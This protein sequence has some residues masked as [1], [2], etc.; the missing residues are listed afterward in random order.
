MFDRTLESLERE[1]GFVVPDPQR[2][3]LKRQMPTPTREQLLGS[4]TNG[5]TYFYRHPDQFQAFE[6]FL[7]T[8]DPST[9]Q[10][11][12]SAG[13]STGCEPYSIAMALDKAHRSGRVLGTDISA[14]RLQEARQGV[15]RES[16]VLRLGFEDK[17]RYFS[18]VGNELWKVK[19]FLTNSVSFELE[20]LTEKTGPGMSRIWDVIFCRN[21][22]IYFDEAMAREILGR[23]VTRLQAGGLLVLGYPEAFFGLSHPE[24]VLLAARTAIFTRVTAQRL[25]PSLML[26]STPPV[27]PVAIRPGAFQEGLRR[28]AMGDLDE[29]RRCFAEAQEKESGL[30]LVH[31]FSARLFDELKQP[32]QAA[33][34]L[35]KFFATYRED[36]PEVLAFTQR[37]GVSLEQLTLAATRLRDRLERSLA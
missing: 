14:E 30:S 19:P 6:G 22:L 32:M 35:Q 13:C 18:S 24:L 8:C 5:Q 21:V 37:N 28:H 1:L 16:R 27:L 23:L 2:L 34:S 9:P 20:N 17:E 36:D 15:Y 10:R 25:Q 33:H 31:Y 4:L 29:A 11:I 26:E 3:L 7:R 12:W